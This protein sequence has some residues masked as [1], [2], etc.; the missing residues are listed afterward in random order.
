MKKDEPM[1]G[2]VAVLGVGL[3][4][5]SFAMAARKRLLCREISGFGR[6][7]ENLMAAKARGIIDS[8]GSDPAEVC[9][10]ADLIFLSSPVGAFTDL[11][12]RASPSF[13]KGAI[14]TDA[15]SVKGNLVYEIEKLMPPEVSYIGGHP[16]AGSD[17]S[18]IDPARAELFE[19]SRCVV[20]PTKKSDKA[21]LEAVIALWKAIGCRVITMEPEAHDRIYA[22]VSHFPHVVAY[23]L[24]NA[25]AEVEPSF[26][27]YSGQGFMDTT[28]IASSP[29]DVWRDICLLN[30]ENLLE[31]ITAF[32]GRLD[33][34][35]R[36]LRASDS[37]SLE[38][39]FTRART[40]REGIGQN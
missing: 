18:G 15:G 28:R 25:V 6:S 26:P 12:R 5:A 35:S 11:V 39:E 13:R 1:F 10:D 3:I 14:V 34:L 16:I 20:T 37:G 27:E 31:L 22:A 29:P 9:M 30:R 8:F 33:M 2:K 7:R 17:R 21:S 32:Q 36:Y 24:V 38:R 4:G 23:A 19:D 40:L